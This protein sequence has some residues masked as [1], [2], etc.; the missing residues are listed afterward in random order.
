M[1]LWLRLQVPASTM[2]I[3]TR[4]AHDAKNA[5]SIL[6]TDLVLL[7]YR[8]NM[9]QKTLAAV[10]K[11]K[12]QAESAL[13]VMRLQEGARAAA[14]AAAEA[15]LQKQAGKWCEEERQRSFKV[16]GELH[17]TKIALTKALRERHE[18]EDK[19]RE[20]SSKLELGAAPSA[21]MSQGCNGSSHGG[22]GGLEKKL[23][24]AT[25]ELEATRGKL[26][27]AYVAVEKVD[28]DMDRMEEALAQ[29]TASILNLE[30]LGKKEAE[31]AARQ[32][33]SLTARLE[34]CQRQLCAAFNERDAAKK[35][36]QDMAARCSDLQR[37]LE[38]AKQ[39]LEQAQES[40]LEA[41]TQAREEMCQLVEDKFALKDKVSSLEEEVAKGKAR[42]EKAQEEALEAEALARE[43]F[44]QLVDEKYALREKVR[45]L[46]EQQSQGV[47]QTE[48]TQS[49]ATE[50][51]AQLLGEKRALQDKVQAL[52]Q[53]L[54][55]AECQR[56]LGTPA[57]KV[58][59]EKLEGAEKELQQLRSR[60]L[61]TNLSII[62]NSGLC[63]CASSCRKVVNRTGAPLARG[64]SG[65][66]ARR[67]SGALKGTGG[68]EVP[69][70][71]GQP[72]EGVGEGASAPGLQQGEPGAPGA[73]QSI[74][75]SRADM[76]TGSRTLF[77]SAVRGQ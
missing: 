29:T 50:D 58:L 7:Q 73:W 71:W 65:S 21:A 36:T 42:L 10:E 47:K 54:A 70:R 17:S 62:V 38:G 35:G 68:L 3:M 48:A 76:S 22:S 45:A 41:E 55:Q 49:R 53:A 25:V 15:E 39:K 37:Q 2:K 4:Q 52:E 33:A 18:F 13:A 27:E 31:E 5:I 56:T 19:A 66:T 9:Q 46:E 43:E 77:A 23:K 51:A 40:A 8:Y 44:T 60:V 67:G 59:E 1:C 30:R 63:G 74:A 6:E 34:S 57:L 32:V 11:G 24:E 69:Y 12:M 61:S 28:V 14:L 75:R 20:L 26:R 64:S 72:G 16:M